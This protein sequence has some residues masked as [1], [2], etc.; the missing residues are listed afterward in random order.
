[1]VRTGW[2][3]VGAVAGEEGEEEGAEVEGAAEEVKAGRQCRDWLV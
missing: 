3:K 2:A 1:M